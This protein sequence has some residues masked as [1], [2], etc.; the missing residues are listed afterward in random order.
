MTLITE[1]W[2]VIGHILVCHYRILCAVSCSHLTDSLFENR[3]EVPL[4]TDWL[5][6]VQTHVSLSGPNQCP[7]QKKNTHTE[8]ERED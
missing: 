2:F 1:H 6:L 4:R 5:M 3:S 8:K 7:T